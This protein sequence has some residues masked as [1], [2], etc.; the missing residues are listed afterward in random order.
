MQL[1]PDQTPSNSFADIQKRKNAENVCNSSGLKWMKDVVLAK[2]NDHS[3]RAVVV[4]D[5]D[6]ELSEIGIPFQIAERLQVPEHVNMQNKEKLFY[7]CELLLLVKGHIKVCRKGSPVLLHK[8]EHLKIG[9][10]FYRPLDDGDIVLIN[11]PPSIHQ[12]SLI[13]LSVRALPISSVVSINPLVC[14]P[15]CGDFDGDCLHGYIPQSVDATVELKELVALDKQLINGQSGR[16]LLSLS[17]DSLTA[18]Y[19]LME[20]VVLLN[21]YQLQQLQMLSPHNLTLPAIEKSCSSE[22]SDWSGKQLFSML[23]PSN[24]VDDWLCDSGYNIAQRIV[25]H[26]QGKSLHFLYGVQKSLCEWLS[27]IGFSVSLSDLYLSSNAHERKNMTEEISWALREAEE[28]CTFKQLLVDYNCNFLSG[29]CEDGEIDM[30]IEAEHLNYER[31]V[32]SA[33]SQASVHAFRRVFRDIQSLACNHACKSNTLL[34]MFK[35]GSKG[36][37]LKLVQHAMCLGLQ[38]SLVRLSY[39]IPYQLSCDGWNSQKC[40]CPDSVQSYVPYAVIES[41]F[42]TGLNPLE[43]FVHSVTNRDSSF[44]GNADLPGTLTRRLMFFMR[45]LYY[46]YDGTVRNLYGNQ[47]IQFSYDPDGDSSSDSFYQECTIGG[48]PVGALSACAI[49]EAAYSA[50]DQPISLLETSPLLSLKNV[51][52]CGSK[53][54]GDQTM[55]LYLSEKLGKHI[56]GFEY[57]ALE[58]KDYLERML[59]SDIVSTVMITYTPNSNRQAK[60]SPWICHFHLHKEIVM[61]RKLKLHSIVNTL[62]QRC[63]SVRKERKVSLPSLKISCNRKCS[64]AYNATDGEDSC[65]EKDKESEDCVKVEIVENSMNTIQLDSVWDLLIPFLL[66]AAIK[67]FMEIKKVDILW[68]N[69][70]KVS[71]SNNGSPGELYLRVSISGDSGS[72]RSWGA[73]INHCFQIMDMIDWTH[74]HPDSIHHICSVYGIDAGREYFLHSLASAISDTG[75]AVLPKHLLLVANSLSASGEFVGLNAKGMALQRQHA[76]VSSP[77][78]ESCFSNPGRCFIKAA[79]SGV[80]DHLQGSLDALAWGKSPTM[81]STGQFDIIFLEGQELAIPVDV[82]NFLEASSGKLNENIN[83][84]TAVQN[85]L[86]DKCSSEFRHKNGGYALKWSKTLESLI[87][88]SVTVNDIRKLLFRSKC[89]L[90]KYS[91]NSTDQQQLGE[92]DKSTMLMLLHFHPN[93]NEKIGIGPQ[94]IK[95]GWH[96]KYKDTHCFFIVRSDGTSEDFSYRKCIIGALEIVHPQ[97]AKTRKKKWLENA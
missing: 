19:L 23:L 48:E 92:R 16:N 18:S 66:G 95:V 80:V 14:S 89:I 94:Y 2:R 28:A 4:G 59:F 88:N 47:L 64:A 11:R 96:P 74:S 67:G 35:A 97:K 58:I 75:K 63:D 25:H 79:K 44:S 54:S 20:D 6:L 78:V 9:D 49:S 60:Y 83:A 22:T 71:R 68:N 46:A 53:K 34:C 45:D 55:S 70:S 61:R 36:N 90:K 13:A 8:K 41:S 50:L 7:Y 21:T 30:T 38:H 73:L 29:V 12:H 91:T 5:P 51:L 26:F 10:I 62:Y 40:V 1:N 65:I 24:S 42:L 77:F 43:C 57:A 15:L 31:Q 56:Y 76:C 37:L 52:E 87:R 86:S 93:R 39:K 72:G 17:Q 3:F 85:N 27:M 82:Y 69:Q 81:G 84:P 32:S 33:L